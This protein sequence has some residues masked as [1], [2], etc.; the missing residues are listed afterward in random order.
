MATMTAPSPPTP[1]TTTFARPCSCTKPQ[2]STSTPKP[3]R[4]RISTALYL[5]SSTY[6]QVTTLVGPDASHP[7]MGNPLPRTAG[8]PQSSPAGHGAQPVSSTALPA[9]EA[10]GHT[11]G[12]PAAAV[13]T[14]GA[15]AA[16][17]P[18][19]A[20]PDRVVRYVYTCRAP[21]AP[22]TRTIA[23]TPMSVPQD[24]GTPSCHVKARVVISNYAIKSSRTPRVR[25]HLT[26][27]TAPNP[28]PAGDRSGVTTCLG[29]GSAQD[30]NGRGPRTPH[31]VPDP[32][33]LSG[34]LSGRG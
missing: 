5:S 1:T 14:S 26:R 9:A 11:S 17:A 4:C 7:A 21:A 23:A 32:H 31:G 24:W 16:A 22:P 28:L 2:P 27:P 34:P 18:P 12:S 10:A 33:I 19:A 25:L 20:T 29:E 8:L 6:L 30:Q 15:S 13:P 3:S